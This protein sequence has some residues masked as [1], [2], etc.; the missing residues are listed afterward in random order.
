MIQSPIQSDGVVCRSYGS[1]EG[2]TSVV[3]WNM[4]GQV[5]SLIVGQ[6]SSVF[7]TLQHPA[8]LGLN[9]VRRVSLHS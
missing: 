3:G 4:G 6:V 1:W 2:R 7:E 5:S 9:F 8:N